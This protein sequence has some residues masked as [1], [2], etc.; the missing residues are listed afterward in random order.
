M[1]IGR[2]P[3]LA[4]SF[5][6]IAE[7]AAAAQIHA[8]IVQRY[9]ELGDLAGLRYAVR[10]LCAH[11]RACDGGL[12]AIAEIEADMACRAGRV[13]RSSDASAVPETRSRSLGQ[14]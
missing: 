12:Q 3:L 13:L 4:D 2:R 11:I 5:E 9:A 14:S 1:T 6:H 7:N 10:C 8:G